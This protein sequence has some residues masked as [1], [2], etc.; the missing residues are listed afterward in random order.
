VLTHCN[1]WPGKSFD[2]NSFVKNL[3]DG[4]FGGYKIS[5]DS[6]LESVGNRVYRV[7]DDIKPFY[8]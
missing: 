6:S 5:I 8:A 7:V 1:S 2:D 3:L 4:E